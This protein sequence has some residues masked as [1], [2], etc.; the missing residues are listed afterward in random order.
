[1]EI[2]VGELSLSFSC[3]RG[4][5]DAHRASSLGRK[6]IATLFKFFPPKKVF[7]GS[8]RLQVLGDHSAA[9]LSLERGRERAR[10]G[11]R[12]SEEGRGG[13]RRGQC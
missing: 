12:K 10:E 1:M 8:Q 9:C 4:Q 7:L 5:S 3:R 13:E 6:N 2:G 11:G